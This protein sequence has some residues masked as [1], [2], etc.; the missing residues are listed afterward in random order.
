MLSGSPFGLKAEESSS[1]WPSQKS[2]RSDSNIAQGHGF[3]PFGVWIL[4][5]DLSGSAA[6]LPTWHTSE[7]DSSRF[8]A[9][10]DVKVAEVVLI[11]NLL[12]RKLSR[13]VYTGARSLAGRS[14][15]NSWSD[16]RRVASPEERCFHLPRHLFHRVLTV[17]C[18]VLCI[19]FP[20]SVAIPPSP[21]MLQD[22][23][24]RTSI[25]HECCLLSI[26]HRLHVAPCAISKSLISFFTETR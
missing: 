1:V 8:L 2:Y 14:S 23:I 17:S 9:L 18:A 6:S 5:T 3:L 19:P 10:A 13:A 11:I 21:R 16:S 24:G 4:L 22:V 25:R 15:S 26:L 20:S 7:N 12:A